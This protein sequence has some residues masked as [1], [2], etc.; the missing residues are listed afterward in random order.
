[1]TETLTHTGP[2]WRWAGGNAAWY[3]V[4]IDGAAGDE[5]SA[6]AL[7][8]RL[9]SGKRNGWGMLKVTARL[10]ASRWSTTVFP[11]KEQGWL[12]PVKKAIRSAEDLSEGDLV[13]V[14]LELV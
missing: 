10:G 2:L 12:L 14:E 4:T 6:T 8:R 5:L 1:M 13:F 7:M 3:F 11:S 9:E